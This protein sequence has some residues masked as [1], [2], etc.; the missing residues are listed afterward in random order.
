MRVSNFKKIAGISLEDV[1][2]ALGKWNI[3]TYHLNTKL[4]QEELEFLNKFFKKE[5]SIQRLK[6]Q[7]EEQK[8]FN[9][10]MDGVT[11]NLN[12]TFFDKEKIDIGLVFEEHKRLIGIVNGIQNKLVPYNDL[13]KFEKGL[14]LRS[15]FKTL[16]FLQ[17]EIKKNRK[18]LQNLIKEKTFTSYLI[19]PDPTLNLSFPDGENPFYSSLGDDE[20]A[21]TASWN[22]D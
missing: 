5:I 4:D 20:E 18:Q 17:Q 19:V 2:Q 10:A 7:E 11:L 13:S 22:I 15:T 1:K 21:H 12:F 14:L 6:T 9:D 3:K 8:F 16:E